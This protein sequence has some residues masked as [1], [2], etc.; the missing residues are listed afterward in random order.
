[1][2]RNVVFDIGGVLLGSGFARSVKGTDGFFGFL[3][4]DDFPQ[5]WKDFDRGVADREDAVRNIVALTG[6]SRERADGF[7]DS[8]LGL[9][10]E[11]PTVTAL[12]ERLRGR[13]YGLYVLSNMPVEYWEHIRR[14]G[15]FGLFDGVCISSLE[16][17]LK[18]DPAFYRL[19][20]DRYGLE[21]RE[22]LFVDDKPANVAA[23]ES[24]GIKGYLFRDAESDVQRLDA[25]LPGAK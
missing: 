5:F 1:M 23:A 2:I 13:G 4:G 7:M 19:L 3:A 17:M 9:L 15:V 22:T 20:L 14:F 16:K 18:P 6:W 12:A 10:V 8:I 25:M 21:P 11:N 24:L